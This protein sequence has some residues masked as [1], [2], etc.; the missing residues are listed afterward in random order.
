MTADP[1]IIY[2]PSTAADWT[3][4]CVDDSN[5]HGP[6]TVLC[7]FAV[8]SSSLITVAGQ[9]LTIAAVTS[10]GTYTRYINAVRMRKHSNRPLVE[11]LPYIAIKDIASLIPRNNPNLSCN[12]DAYGWRYPGKVMLSVNGIKIT[13]AAIVPQFFRFAWARTGRGK[14]R[15]LIVC[16]CRRKAQIL[17]F[18]GGRYACKHCHRADYLC[19]HLSKGRQKLWKAARLRLQLNG[20]PSDYA[21]PKRPK[22]TRLKHYRRLID[23][24]ASLELKARKA[25]NKQFDTG[26]YAY[27]LT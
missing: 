6:R 21:L 18:Y 24:I 14:H 1:R 12:P 26:F 27:H 3:S 8:A 2:G 11:R 22:G 4:T 17:Y 23:R 25:R 20:L 9:K 7:S 19:Q 10:L 15:P 13:D 16:Q 5:R